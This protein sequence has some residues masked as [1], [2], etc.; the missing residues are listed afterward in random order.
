MLARYASRYGFN[1]QILNQFLVFVLYAATMS[2]TGLSC[3]NLSEQT[4]QIYDH[5]FGRELRGGC[6]KF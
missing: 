3:E 5:P 2:H 6:P 4:L 1:D